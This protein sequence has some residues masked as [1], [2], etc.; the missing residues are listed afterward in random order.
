MAEKEAAKRA[1]STNPAAKVAK[2]ANNGKKPQFVKKTSKVDKQDSEIQK[3]NVGILE[4]SEAQFQNSSSEEIK[5]TDFPISSNLLKGLKESEFT[6]PTAIQKSSLIW[7]LRGHD[8]LGGAKT[9]SGK[10]LA[11]LI[12]L[13]ELLYREKWSHLDGLGA[14]IL[15]PTRDEAFER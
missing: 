7:T 13:L 15:T 10:T 11:F 14:L 4:L 12:P 3:L 8:V 6:S 2:A 5:F 9:G 1:I